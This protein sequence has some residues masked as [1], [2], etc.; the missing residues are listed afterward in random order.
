MRKLSILTILLFLSFIP[1]PTKGEVIDRILAQVGDEIVTWHDVLMYAPSQVR[2]I[3]TLPESEKKSAMDA[4]INSTLNIII[5]SRVLEISANR[6]GVFVADAEVDD[7][8]VNISSQ[9]YAFR[10]AVQTVMNREGRVTPEIRLFVKTVLLQEKLRPV[11]INRAVVAEEEVYEKLKSDPASSIGEDEYD[12]S[13]IFFPDRAVYNN[14]TEKV[15]TSDFFKAAEETG[16]SVIKMGYITKGYLL[17][18]IASRLD[19]IAVGSISEP[20]VDS[21]GR[22]MVLMVGDVRKKT[23]VSEQVLEAA[24]ENMRSERMDMVFQNWLD[25]SRQSI[26]IHKEI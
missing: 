26:V 9:N 22:Y 17:P 19:K 12:L 20:I 18:E 23:A 10:N 16:Q 1:T 15:K 14:F 5:D 21:E 11:L 3:N 25:K 6:M 13:I 8:I 7:L 2:Q 24:E 4:Y